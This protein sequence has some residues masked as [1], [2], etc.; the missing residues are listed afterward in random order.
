M[1]RPRF[2]P[3]VTEADLPVGFMRWNPV[4]RG[5]RWGRWPWWLDVGV[6]WTKVSCWRRSIYDHYHLYSTLLYFRSFLFDDKSVFIGSGAEGCRRL[7]FLSWMLPSWLCFPAAPTFTPWFPDFFRSEVCWLSEHV[8]PD[9]WK[10][11]LGAFW[12]KFSMVFPMVSYVFL[13]P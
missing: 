11:D 2:G 4:S 3:A 9:D 5:E 13:I 8:E 10:C 12:S 6:P 1:F 7:H